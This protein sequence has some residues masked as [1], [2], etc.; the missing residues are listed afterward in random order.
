MPYSTKPSPLVGK[1]LML[2]PRNLPIMPIKIVGCD[3]SIGIS[4][5]FDRA[6]YDCYCLCIT[7]PTIYKKRHQYD[8]KIKICNTVKQYNKEYTALTNYLE[9]NYTVFFN[10]IIRICN[11]SV[12]TG[13]II[14]SESCPFS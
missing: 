14:T 3:R 11:L 10:D 4:I 12:P 9:K 5:I 8:K 13:L 6:P 1:K 2:I 7:H